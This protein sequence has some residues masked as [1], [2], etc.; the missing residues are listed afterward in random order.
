MNTRLLLTFIGSQVLEFSF[1]WVLAAMLSG[2]VGIPTLKI[3]LIIL[4]IDI[5]ATAIV[6]RNQIP[7][8]VDTL[9]NKDS[10]NE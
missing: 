5:I 2:F 3:F 6:F 10:E 8:F 9:L 4:G 1:F 7:L